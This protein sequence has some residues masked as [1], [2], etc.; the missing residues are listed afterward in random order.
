MRRAET[1]GQKAKGFQMSDQALAVSRPPERGLG[2]R[3]R[4]MGLQRHLVLARK[5][6]TT[7]Q[8]LIRAMQRD[9]W[10]QRRTNK[11]AVEFP[12]RQDVCTYR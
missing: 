1:L 4:Q 10:A 7:D 12:I 2:A 8:E 5:L 9:G 6:R 11:V 3:F